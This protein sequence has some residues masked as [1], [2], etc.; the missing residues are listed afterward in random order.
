MV[1]EKGTV[2]G[3]LKEVSIFDGQDS[4]WTDTSCSPRL[5]RVDSTQETRD[6][7]SRREELQRQLVVGSN[8]SE[9]ERLSLIDCLIMFNM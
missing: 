1:I 6:G 4:L 5:C 2:V 3:R 7:I 9:E 8:C